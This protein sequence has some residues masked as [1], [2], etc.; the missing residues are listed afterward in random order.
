MTGPLL[1]VTDL[2]VHYGDFQALYGVSLAVT[3]GETLALMGANGAGKSTLLNTV[4]GLRAATSGQVQFAGRDLAG[5]PAFQRVAVGIAL[6][7]EGRR[8]FPTLT[9]HENLLVGEYR[10]RPGPWRLG[11]VY[12]L[13]PFL[14]PLRDR[15]A[16]LLSGGEQQAVAIGRALMSNPRLLLFDEVSLGLAPVVIQQLYGV[17]ARITAAG[18]TV[19]LVEQDVGRALGAADRVHCLL[20]GRT[21]LTGAASGITR[22]ALS[23][24]YFGV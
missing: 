6:V 18:T 12:E 13:F 10:A 22:E 3:D 7:P 4:A 1:E 11:A 24:A 8:L 9:A 19:L 2:V 5:M 20:E 17:L 23:V 16:A 14:E 21:A 15:P